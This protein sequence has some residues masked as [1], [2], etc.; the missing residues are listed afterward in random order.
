MVK[1][2][3]PADVLT[4]QSAGV[5]WL[6][7]PLPL[8]P[9]LQLGWPTGCPLLLRVLVFS[10]LGSALWPPVRAYGLL[11]IETAFQKR[12]LCLYGGK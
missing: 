4:G 8:L 10:G 5:E 7:N 11:L 6:N 12:V 1:S 9:S 3:S 2:E